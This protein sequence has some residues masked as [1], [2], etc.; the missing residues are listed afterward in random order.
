MWQ[1]DWR[2]VGVVMITVVVYMLYTYQATE[3]RIGI[4]RRMNESDT[5]A[6]HQ[7]DRLAAQLRDGEIF[8]R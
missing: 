8:Q 6:K 3:W 1:F 4:R 5:D 7:G 2:Y